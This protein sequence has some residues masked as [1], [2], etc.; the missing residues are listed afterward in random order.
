MTAKEAISH[1]ENQE[2]RVA[3]RSVSADMPLFDVLPILLDS[4]GRILSVTDA[5]NALIGLIDSRSLLEALGRMIAARYDCSVIEAECAA[6]DYSASILARAV[7]DCDVH[8]VDLLSA[9]APEGRIAITLRVRCDDPTLV[10]NSLV[11]YGY[12]VKSTS[13]HS[14]AQASAALERLLE[15][16]ALMNV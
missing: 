8:L 15:L 11:R 13:G 16:R 5:D 6:A 10:A 12:D 4:P 14:N 1:L 3:S 7:E 9:P 2:M